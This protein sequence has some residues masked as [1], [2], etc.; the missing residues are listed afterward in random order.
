MKRILKY[1]AS[2]LA[3]WWAG[4]LVIGAILYFSNN[5]SDFTVTDIMGF[6]VMAIVAS[7]FLMLLIYLPALHFL[8]RRL[9]AQPHLRSALLTGVL[10]NL[11]IYIVLTFLAGRKM[12]LGEALGFMVTFLIIGLVFGFGV[13]PTSVQN[14]SK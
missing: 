12:V 6:G 10:C 2:A 13:A 7:G 5:G 8:K 3:A 14:P 1:I 9:L 4:L 11:P